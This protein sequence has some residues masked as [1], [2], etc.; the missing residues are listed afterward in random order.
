[1]SVKKLEKKPKPAA[2]EAPE[3]IEVTAGTEDAEV[4]SEAPAVMEETAELTESAETPES[5]EAAESTETAE[6]KEEETTAEEEEK[7][8][9]KGG[10]KPLYQVAYKRDDSVLLAFI[11]FN[12]RVVHPKVFLR[13]ILYAIVFITFGVVASSAVF[14]AICFLL[15]AF[16]LGLVM[17]RKNISLNMTKKDD[18]DYINGTVY[19]YNFTANGARMLRD[20]KPEVYAKSYKS[21]VKAFFGDQSFYYLLVSPDDLF[22]LPKDRFTI[23]DP[24]EFKDFII[25]KTGLEM[26]WIPYGI[27]GVLNSLK[28][29]SQQPV[30]DTEGWKELVSNR[31]DK[32]R[33]EKSAAEEEKKSASVKPKSLKDKNK[34]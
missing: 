23:G 14:S 31:R 22:V 34:K 21:S 29:F 27:K 6:I 17:F 7:Q 4:I 13:S 12:Y 25:E 8:P 19:T 1:M 11:T 28:N 10:N 33:A 2:A 18:Q 3:E 20:N 26:R 9:K 5:A 30:I 24:E 16:C 32:R 15:A